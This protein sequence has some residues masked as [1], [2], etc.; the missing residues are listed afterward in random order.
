M[1]HRVIVTNSLNYLTKA[2]LLSF[3]MVLFLANVHASNENTSNRRV[4]I[5]EFPTT[6]E[7]RF[8]MYYTHLMDNIQHPKS[9]YYL[10]S[11]PT[12][13]EIL[14]AATK[15][16][17]YSFILINKDRLMLARYNFKFNE[18]NQTEIHIEEYSSGKD[19]TLPNISLSSIPEHRFFEI[20][21]YI[22]NEQ[23]L[24]VSSTINTLDSLNK[25]LKTYELEPSNLYIPTQIEIND[26]FLEFTYDNKKNRSEFTEEQWLETCYDWAQKGYQYGINDYEILYLIYEYIYDDIPLDKK[27]KAHIK[28]GFNGL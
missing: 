4:F 21:E 17:T 27:T 25:V 1:G 5:I 12:K 15:L 7:T 8:V 26:A 10:N 23:M 18:D 24:S 13:A 19:Y 20:Q 9:I 3:L 6:E 16:P 22:K 11:K 2:I 14:H 28:D